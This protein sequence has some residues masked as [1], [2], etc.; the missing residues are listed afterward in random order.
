MS[1]AELIEE[2]RPNFEAIAYG[3]YC[4]NTK[5]RNR[6]PVPMEVYLSRLCLADGTRQDAYQLVDVNRQ[7]VGYKSCF[8]VLADSGVLSLNKEI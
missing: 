1:I 4:S 5:R 8:R 7:W 3:R 6:I 2:H